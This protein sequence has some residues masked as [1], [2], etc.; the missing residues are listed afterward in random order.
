[1]PY[2][3]NPFTGNF[4]IVDTNTAA[5]SDTQ[6]QFNDGGTLAGDT[7]LTWN[8]TSDQLTVGGDIN[9]DSGGNFSTT[10]Q[11][12]TPTAN[13]TISFPDQTGT[14]GLVSGATGNIQ[15]NNAGQ[16]AGTAD[17]NVSLDWTNAAIAYTGLKVNVTDTASAAGSK[18]FDLQSNGTSQVSVDSSGSLEVASELVNSITVG[19]GAGAISSNTAVGSGALQANTTG[20]NNTANG[21]SALSSNTTGN[22]STATGYQALRSNTTGNNNTAN[23]YQSLLSNTTGNNNTANGYQAL[24]FNTTGSSNTANGLQSLYSNTIGAA[25]T[26][27]GFQSLYSNTTGNNNT[28]NGLQSLYNNTTGNNNTANG[29]SALYSNTTGNSNT[30]N[31]R[32]A[33]YNNTTGAGN[34]CLGS[35][36][37]AGTYAPV[38]DCTTENNR[39]VV[40]STAVTNAYIQVAWTVVSDERDKTNFDLVPHGLDFVKQ[41]NPVAFQFKESRDSDIP[42]GPVRYGFKAQDILALEGD[43]NAVII[44]NE[45]P[46]KLRYNGEAL[47]PVLVNAIKELAAEN[48]ALKARL[49]AAGI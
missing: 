16:L 41:L 36:N 44:D 8:K 35:L 40:G 6:V 32:E 10:I 33:L 13:R 18:L 3:F 31:G 14:V 26:A 34:V 22:S 25:N 28:A 2:V 49:D 7:A 21:V 48:A 38:F 43:D 27:N 9:L 12:V 24:V 11:S 39:V 19:R 17:L 20:I 4:D 30:A 45:N 23:G 1:M 46:D 5:G 47:V 42:H 15:Y 37:N 29:S